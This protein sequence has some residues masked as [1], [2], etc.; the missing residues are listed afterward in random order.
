MKLSHYMKIFPSP[1][2]PGYV[3]LYSTLRGSVAAIPAQ[4]LASLQEGVF[5]VE[6]CEALTRLG[7]LV[8]DPDVEREQMRGLID[9]ANAGP[10]HFMASVVLN[11]D[12]NLDCGY[13][14]EGEFRCG[15]YMSEETADL[16][17]ETLVRERISQGW[18]VTVSFYGG[19]P[20]LS[21]D[22]IRRISQPLQAAA[23]HHGVKYA[24][25]LVT[26][27]T[28]LDR[29]TVLQLLPLGLQGAKFTLDGPREIHDVQRP[30]ASGAGSFEII[31]ANLAQ[32][33]DLISIQLG[34]NFR[35]ENYREFPRLLDQ[36]P[37]YGVTPD[38]LSV[39]MFTPV[40]STGGCSDFNTGCALSEEPWLMEAAPFLREATLA[41]G[42]RAPTLKPSA[43]VVELDDNLVIDCTG[44][45]YKCPAFMGSEEMSI[46]GLREGLQ[47]YRASHGIGN[48]QVD[49]CLEC[50]YLPLCFGGCRFVSKLQGKSLTEVDCRRKFYDATLEQTVLQNLTYLAPRKKGSAQSAPAQ[51][52]PPY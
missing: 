25:T 23:L 39:V 16:L 1:D 7:M 17:V 50:S 19:E 31:A 41:R 3:L 44:K 29:D 10:R 22:L 27:G 9:R 43:C 47:D 21:Q 4:T 52:A 45:F 2:R 49:A 33:C 36:L 5:P 32:V 40:V 12:C 24:F 18:D 11:L 30:Y 38:K 42:Y 15:H 6:G 13:C 35:P 34:A 14:F 48:W 28:L 46:G 8:E 51:A 26:N 20:L 37:L